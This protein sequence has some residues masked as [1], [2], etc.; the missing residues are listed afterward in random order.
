MQ[1]LSDDDFE[2]DAVRRIHAD[3]SRQTFFM[4]GLFAGLTVIGTET[5]HC[6]EIWPV[7]P[8]MW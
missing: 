7:L 1:P 2:Q 4:V 3:S 5:L 8:E 6:D